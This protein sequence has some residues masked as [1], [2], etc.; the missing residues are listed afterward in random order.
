MILA[1]DVLSGI[2]DTITEEFCESYGDYQKGKA[3]IQKILT[4]QKVDVKNPTKE[5]LLKA[6]ERVGAEEEIL[7]GADVAKKNKEVRMFKVKKFT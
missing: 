7:L 1:L 3:I 6:I 5:G 4:E 2:L